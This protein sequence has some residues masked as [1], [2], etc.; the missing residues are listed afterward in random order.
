LKNCC[1][2][3]CLFNAVTAEP[4][5]NHSRLKEPHRPCHFLVFVFDSPP[6]IYARSSSGIVSGLR[7]RVPMS[8]MLNL[9]D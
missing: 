5:L 3:L 7:V 6:V 4:H 1:S 9:E 8:G 2:P